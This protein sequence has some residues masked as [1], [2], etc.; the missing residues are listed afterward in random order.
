VRG[1]AEGRI[2]RSGDRGNSV[3]SKL[4]GASIVALG[5]SFVGAKSQR[6]TTMAIYLSLSVAPKKAVGTSHFLLSDIASY[7]ALQGAKEG[8]SRSDSRVGAQGGVGSQV[9]IRV[10]ARARRVLPVRLSHCA[11]EDR[12]SHAPT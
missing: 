12:L 5:A 7:R 1:A 6:T 9:G 8:I 10:H 3:F 4:V 11:E 2:C